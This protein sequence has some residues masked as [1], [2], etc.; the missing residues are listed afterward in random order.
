MYMASLC[1]AYTVIIITKKV[2][3][4]LDIFLKPYVGTGNKISNLYKQYL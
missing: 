4:F 1:V 2:K 3:K